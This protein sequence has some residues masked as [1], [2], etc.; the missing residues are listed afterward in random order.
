MRVVIDLGELELMHGGDL[1]SGMCK[2]ESQAGEL[3][4]LIGM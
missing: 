3:S 2:E 4:G 1:V